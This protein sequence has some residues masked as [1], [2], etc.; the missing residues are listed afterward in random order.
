MVLHNNKWD[1]KAKRRYL[2]KKKKALLNE[3]SNK[4]SNANNQAN[5]I[6]NADEEQTNDNQSD[7]QS[8]HDSDNKSGTEVNNDLDNEVDNRDIPFEEDDLEE[9]LHYLS[10]AKS[11][12]QTKVEGDSTIKSQIV[13]KKPNKYEKRNQINKA[14]F[15][16]YGSNQKKANDTHTVLSKEE[17]EHFAQL[18]EKIKRQ[19]L[20]DD[21]KKK[22]S[23]VDSR[24]SELV[25]RSRNKSNGKVMRL[26]SKS[27]IL[28][29]DDSNE[30]RDR[31]QIDLLISESLASSQKAR[32]HENFEQ[33]LKD[34]LNVNVA[35]E[36]PT[37]NRSTSTT[38][39]LGAGALPQQP[40]LDFLDKLLNL[41]QH[42]G[43]P[44]HL[45]SRT[46]SPP[47]RQLQHVQHAQLED[48]LR[49]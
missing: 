7:N 43:S 5:D 42:C 6:N 31:E 38:S 9:S 17:E 30:K 29:K 32:K 11:K 36:R 28:V 15:D 1:K 4:E 49:P 33:D 46:C 34:L 21:L 3:N 40:D 44:A 45:S 20:L 10:L 27:K 41:N 37:S 26:D 22:F 12:I 16:S 39:L 14:K 8:N 47:L 48:L 23:P 19:K 18:Q 25:F 24:S 2:A 35:G 13:G